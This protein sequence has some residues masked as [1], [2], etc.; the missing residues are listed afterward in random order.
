MPVAIWNG[1]DA[2]VWPPRRTPYDTQAIFTGS[3]VV[4]D[5]A[6]PGGKG[7]GVVQIYPGLCTKDL[8]PN[9]TTGTLLA[10]AVPADYS[11]DELLTNWTK[12][13]YNPIIEGTQ[14]DP[15]TP[16]KTV[17]GEWRLRTFDSMLYGAASDADLLAGRWYEIGRSSQFKQCECPSFYLL[18]QPTP[19]FEDAYHAAAA[20][21]G[22]PTHVHKYSCAGDWWQLGTYQE[23]GPRTAG[24][25]TATPGWEDQF[26]ARKIDAGGY[27]ASKDNEYPTKSGGKRRVNW[28][29][30]RVPPGSAQ[31]LP[32]V[33][34]FNAATRRLEQA[35]LEE[36]QA[37]RGPAAYTAKDLELRAQ[38]VEDLGLKPG[39]AKYSDI[40]AVF[41]LP[42]GASSFGVSIDRA[43]CN[44]DYTPPAN[45]SMP[46]YEVPV[47]CNKLK[48]TVRLTP[49]EKTIEVRVFADA[50]F[51]EAYF[52]KGRAAMTLAVPMTDA[53]RVAVASKAS[54]VVQSVEV[55]PMKSIWVQ[56]E[57]VR[58]TPRV[59]PAVQGLFV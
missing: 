59:Y 22:L 42:V 16:W 1:L 56:P 14:R 28:G 43:S 48:D 21:G 41:A 8:W 51:I 29:W 5:A 20:S 45:A 19:G 54:I 17:G 31:S 52:Q 13:S 35:P 55:Y 3:A 27:Y 2:S 12:P 11:S 37:L 23:G 57:D 46:F 30:A 39:V 34:T 10:Q 38:G 26:A 36:L 50:T 58:K 33:V 4:L 7:P 24:D 47:S 25:F 32:R 15:S 18:P 49:G 40:V 44:V 6:G 53:T 9:C